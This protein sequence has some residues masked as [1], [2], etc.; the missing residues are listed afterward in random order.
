MH[1]VGVSRLITA[2]LALIAVP[3]LAKV[4]ALGQLGVLAALLAALVA[5]ES[6][7]FAQERDE[8]KHGEQHA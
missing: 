4:P 2:G 6:I 8:L 1:Q 3:L 7:R 5:F